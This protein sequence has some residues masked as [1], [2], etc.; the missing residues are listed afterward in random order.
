MGIH[1]IG[2]NLNDI[3]ILVYIM[4]HALCQFWRA[5]EFYSRLILNFLTPKRVSL[6]TLF[7]LYYVLGHVWF[8][9][10]LLPS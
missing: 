3:H 7:F 6:S 10:T 8:L 9:A 5:S 4:Y 2:T 1:I